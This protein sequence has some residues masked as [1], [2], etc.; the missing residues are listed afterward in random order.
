MYVAPA[1]V[2]E[3]Q[4]LLVFRQGNNFGSIVDWIAF[5]LANHKP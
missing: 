5:A 1:A 3:A 2:V 4:Q